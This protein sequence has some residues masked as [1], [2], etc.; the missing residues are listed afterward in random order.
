MMNSNY[1]ENIKDKVI[2]KGLIFSHEVDR[3]GLNEDSVLL[4]LR[5]VL[6]SCETVSVNED[7]QINHYVFNVG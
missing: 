5:R 6:V 4:C 1:S 3:G 2:F 7:I